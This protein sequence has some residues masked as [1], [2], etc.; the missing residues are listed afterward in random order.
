MKKYV[1]LLFLLFFNLSLFSVTELEVLWEKGIKNSYEIISSKYSQE[2][3]L[4]SLKYKNILYPYSMNSKI[5]SSFTDGYSSVAWYP[6]SSGIDVAFSKQNPGGNVVS[7]NL[8][9]GFN[10]SILDIFS[11]VT[12]ENIGYS[13]VPSISLGVSQ[14][15]NPFFFQGLKTDPNI[16][17][18]KE[19]V[20][21]AQCE[22]ATVERAIIENI[23]ANYIQ[24]R[25]LIRLLNKSEKYLDFYQKYQSLIEEQ[26][27]SGFAATSDLWN[28]QKNYW[29]IYEEYVEYFNAKENVLMNLRNYSKEVVSVSVSAELPS[30][31]FCREEMNPYEQLIMLQMNK[32]K[33]QH[34]INNQSYSP[35]ISFFGSFSESVKA[36][37][38]FLIN[39]IEDKLTFSWDFSIGI[40]FDDFFSPSKK[41][42][43]NLYENN[44]KLYSEELH[45][46]KNQMDNQ[47][48]NYS[49]LI[50]SCVKQIK[51]VEVIFENCK[52][53]LENYNQLFISGKCSEIELE[54]VKLKFFDI[55]CIY[56]N[57]KDSLWL[58]T[59]KRS[60]YI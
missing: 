10:R 28:I 38:N 30:D 46:L 51:N 17:I 56:E 7:L 53:N 54:E 41:L 5:S 35:V 26:I 21:L 55:E 31:F 4:E 45:V 6:I 15:L 42:R 11:D 27:S 49:A 20:K 44:M 36:T 32:E 8:N 39:Y 2:Y 33:I 47:K 58:N 25:C 22:Q 12:S 34:V 57:L 52:K 16:L 60:L 37:D 19:N 40:C 59:W 23:A 48:D 29:D 50:D 43:Q 13:Q 24:F 14:S 9:Y 1:C 18:L 3:A